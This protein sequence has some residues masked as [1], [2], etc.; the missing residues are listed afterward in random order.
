MEEKVKER[1]EKPDNISQEEMMNIFIH[2]R[3]HQCM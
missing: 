2:G 3:L 1:L